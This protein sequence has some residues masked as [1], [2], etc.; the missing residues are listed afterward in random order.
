MDLTSFAMVAGTTEYRHRDQTLL[1]EDLYEKI[2][3]EFIR[4]SI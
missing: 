3:V 1:Y 4:E 2:S